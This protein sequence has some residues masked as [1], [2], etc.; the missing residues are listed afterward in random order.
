MLA[1]VDVQARM[2]S[3][4][5]SSSNIYFRDDDICENIQELGHQRAVLYSSV[6]NSFKII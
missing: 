5:A 4:D 3:R 6:L 2:V 1:I